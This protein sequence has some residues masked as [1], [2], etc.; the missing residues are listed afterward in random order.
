MSGL[1]WIESPV[2]GLRAV[3]SV[4]ALTAALV[5]CASESEAPSTLPSL[6]GGPSPSAAP[7]PASTP[8]AVS[9]PNAEGASAFGRYFYEEIEEA[10]ATRDPGRVAALSSPDCVICKRYIDSVTA[11]RENDEHVDDYDITVL[12]SDAPAT[13]DNMAR[14]TVIY[15]DSASTRKDAKGRVL[16]SEPGRQNV[17]AELVLAR[18]G[19]SWV[20]TEVRRG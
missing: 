10:F 13:S 3:A 2:M 18:Q 1:P 8:S 11:L 14:V 4:V 6:T 19:A 7:S 12:S 17:A 9:A 15:N 5:G 20:V 16:D